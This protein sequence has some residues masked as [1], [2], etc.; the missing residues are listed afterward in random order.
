[1]TRQVIKAFGIIGALDPYKQR[2][3]QLTLEGR[4]EEEDALGTGKTVKTPEKDGITDALTHL[5]PS[6]EEYYP[7]ITIAS[8]MRILKDPSLSQYRNLVIHALMF[9]IKSLGIKSIQ[10]LPQVIIPSS[11]DD[12]L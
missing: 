5:S 11:R 3:N 10:F 6:M 9:I 1:M 12:S 7:T 2:I 8:L 4:E